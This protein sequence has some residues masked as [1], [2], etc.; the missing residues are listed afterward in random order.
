[1]STRVTPGGSSPFNGRS[2]NVI[3]I[4]WAL[5]MP[6]HKR[7]KTAR[8]LL[9]T[10]LCKEV[11]GRVYKKKNQGKQEGE[12]KTAS[13]NSPQFSNRADLTPF[14]TMPSPTCHTLAPSRPLSA[15]PPSTPSA[16]PSRRARRSRLSRRRLLLANM[17]SA[18]RYHRSAPHSA[19]P[20]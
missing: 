3:A 7:M 4:F 10:R 12:D 17:R 8:E 16:P 6:Q 1:M 13:K 9:R 11:M 2:S 19:H 18:R 20:G 5:P 15:H 14:P